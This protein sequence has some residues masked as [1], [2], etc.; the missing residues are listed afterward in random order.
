MTPAGQAI[1]ALAWEG[2]ALRVLDQTLLPE[3]EEWIDLAGAQDTAQAIARLAV[4]GAPLI[5]IVAGYGLA[6][7][8]RRDARHLEA[9]A[10]LLAGARPTAVNLRWAVD[11]V[12][13]AARR[14]GA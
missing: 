8:A 13:A 14:G 10:S 2:G 11:R 12:A 4:R 1:R 5:G 7:E 3:R 6:L 9:A